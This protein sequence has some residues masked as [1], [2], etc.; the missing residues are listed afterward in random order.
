MFL[1]YGP[2]ATGKT[3]YID[4]LL[5]LFGTFVRKSELFELLQRAVEEMKST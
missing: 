3:T 5:R 1:I 4:T 2:A